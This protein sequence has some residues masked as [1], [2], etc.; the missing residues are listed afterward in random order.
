MPQS[1]VERELKFDVKAGFVVPDVA[2]LL[3]AGGRTQTSSEHLRSDYFD[4][5]DRALLRARMTLRR[6]TGTTDTGWQ[7][8]VP[9][10]RFREEIRVDSTEEAVPDELRTL[11]T[12]IGRGQE[13]TRIA[14]VSTNRLVT[15]LLDAEGSTLAEIDDDT[16]HATA[17]GEAATASSWR[18]VEVELGSDELEL[19][20]AL[21]KQ[22]RRAG[23]RPSASASKLARALP[24]SRDRPV[25]G[26]PRAG[27]VILAYLAEQQQVIL[28][29]DLALRRG[30]DSVI[31]HTRVASR[32]L[33]ST[34]RVF[35]PLVDP[36]R[37]AVLD[38]EL[39]WFAGLL[40]EVR[41][42][43]VLR[44]RL[45]KMLD[46]V[47]D[48]LMLGT[49]R[50]RIDSELRHEQSEHWQALQHEL[51]GERY[52][53]MLGDL[54]AW[55][56]LPPLTAKARSKPDSI[57]AY[58][59][60]AEHKVAQRLAKANATGDIHLLHGARKAAKRA[61]YAAEAAEPVIGA[62]PAAQQAKRYR[63]LQDLLGEHQDS[64]VSADLLRRLG[65][66]AG[67]IVGENG[68]AFGI[69]HEREE[70]NAA[71]AR[72][73]AQKIAKKYQ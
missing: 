47:D 38:G 61:R 46:E 57:A 12:G 56:R 7:L 33:R 48:S 52:L 66:K 31:H 59:A 5:H 37:A 49:V 11:L 36:R 71:K 51:T 27:D 73:T 45:D 2:G 32:R 50:A 72:A 54:D 40:G 21:G 70:Q 24:A 6:R 68:F 63:A 13:L 67:T 58:V 9:R 42:R 69:L 26:K 22:L 28:A 39:R 29:G 43:Q 44:L 23:A 3:P 35:G 15:R 55:V 53:A 10:D 18:E 20:Y 25:K 14:S 16:V 34:L 1:Y 8:K 60:R 62:H 4:T 41:D 64:L 65:A 30:D 17:A 19:L